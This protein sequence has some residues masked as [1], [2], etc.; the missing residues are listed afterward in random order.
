MRADVPIKSRHNLSGHPLHPV[1]MKM[2]DRCRRAG[3]PDYPNYGGRGI[4]VCVRWE[5]F[6]NFLQDMGER[7][8]G[9]TLERRDNDGDY[10]PD[11]CVWATRKEQRANQRRV[12]A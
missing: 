9:L 5:H 6:P 11:N 8:F 10:E 1:W 12:V 2:L 7:P 3:N 4:H